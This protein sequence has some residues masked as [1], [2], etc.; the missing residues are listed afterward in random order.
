MKFIFLGLIIIFFLILISCKQIHRILPQGSVI[1][2][3]EMNQL[4][5]SPLPSPSYG[6]VKQEQKF[7]NIPFLIWAADY[8][9]DIVLVSNHPQWNMHELARIQSPSGP[10]WIMKDAD[11]ENLRQRIIC[12]K[13]N[14]EHWLPEIP[15]SR[16]SKSVKISDL[17]RGEELDLQF[18]YENSAGE[19]CEI[20]YQGKF[21]RTV[22]KK[23]NGSTMG[24]SKQDLIAVLDLPTRDFAT[25]ASIKFDHKEY[26][27]KKLLGLLPFQMALQ[28]TQA[29]ISAARYQQMENEN[30]VILEILH[31]QSKPNLIFDIKK[32]GEFIVLS[33]KD[34]LRTINYFFTV[35]KYQELVKANVEIWNKEIAAF[36]IEFFPYLADSRFALNQD[37]ESYFVMHVNGQKGHARGK[38][39]QSKTEKNSQLRIL[40]FKPWWVEDR[41]MLVSQKWEGNFQFWQSEIINR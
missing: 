11:Q 27:I 34:S 30:Q 41:P 32:D 14:L 24:H 9:L 8:D 25:K 37:F 35:G 15:V 33:T 23:R 13:E 1:S 5:Q 29:G 21:P 22:Q 7:P 3:S 38:V 20:S 16:F 36:E 4:K 17:S 12:E 39:I 19:L 2:N 40:P 10:I 18:S 26:K 6:A 28:Q 31:F